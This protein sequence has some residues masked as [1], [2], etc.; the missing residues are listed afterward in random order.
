MS[1]SSLF[2]TG[3]SGGRTIDI[4]ITGPDLEGLVQ[5]A[6]KRSALTMA[7]FPMNEG[8]QLRPIP[9]LDLS[10][11]EMHVVPKLEKAAELGVTST[12]LGYAVNALVDKSSSP[13]TTGM[14]V[15]GSIW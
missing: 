10:S 1:Q 13:V 14:K 15:A 2:D 12:S 11:P 3:L 8:N 5:E 7:L 6:Q 9:G 4:D